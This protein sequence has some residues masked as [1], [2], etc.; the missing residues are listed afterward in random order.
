MAYELSWLER[1]VNNSVKHFFKTNHIGHI[2]IELI[3]NWLADLVIGLQIVVR[4]PI[5]EGQ[6]GNYICYAGCTKKMN[7]ARSNSLRNIDGHVL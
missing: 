3:C 7:E 6:Y 2:R 1:C 4:K 5:M